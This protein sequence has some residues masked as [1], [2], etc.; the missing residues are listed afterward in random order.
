MEEEGLEPCVSRS[1]G[2]SDFGSPCDIIISEA[3]KRVDAPGKQAAA[4][5]VDARELD[6]Q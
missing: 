3:E 2:A 6:P 1:S 4:V 5:L